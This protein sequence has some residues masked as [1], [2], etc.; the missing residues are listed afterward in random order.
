MSVR[1]FTDRLF[2]LTN[3]EEMYLT[4]KST[5]LNSVTNILIWFFFSAKYRE[6]QIKKSKPLFPKPIKAQTQFSL[7]LVQ[8]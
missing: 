2:K 5:C 3:L 1:I 7:T 8:P 6:S 4:A